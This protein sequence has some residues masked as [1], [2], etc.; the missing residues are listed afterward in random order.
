MSKVKHQLL[1]VDNP[2]YIGASGATLS[3]SRNGFP[4][5]LIMGFSSKNSVPSLTARIKA[6]LDRAA[7]FSLALK[8]S[9]PNE[10]RERHLS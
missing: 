5:L 8:A 10:N 6:D 7:R 4:A 2:A 3:G 9:P 1:S